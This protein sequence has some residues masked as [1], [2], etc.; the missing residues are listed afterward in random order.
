MQR[1]TRPR[2]SEAMVGYRDH[3]SLMWRMLRS[4]DL[5]ATIEANRRNAQRSTGPRTQ[6][7]QRQLRLNSVRHELTAETVPRRGRFQGIRS[8]N[9]RGH[10]VRKRPRRS[11]RAF[12]N[13]TQRAWESA[14]GPEFLGSSKTHV[15][16]D[17]A[18]SPSADEY[19]FQALKH[20]I[21]SS[22]RSKRTSASCIEEIRTSRR[23]APP[24]SA[25]RPKS[26]KIGIATKRHPSHSS[27]VSPRPWPAVIALLNYVALPECSGSGKS[28]SIL[29]GARLSFNQE[30]A[31]AAERFPPRE[32]LG[33]RRNCG[34]E[35]A[36]ADRAIRPV[37]CKQSHR[38]TLLGSE[39]V[40]ALWISFRSLPGLDMSIKSGLLR[41]F[42]RLLPFAVVNRGSQLAGGNRRP[43][44]QVEN[45]S[46]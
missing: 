8:D 46:I 41:C 27:R 6:D 30:A 10:I 36:M 29:D 12:L 7:G 21:Q 45:V 14:T 24:R 26:A 4:D 37:P 33:A 17:P 15:A 5:V 1:A 16:R 9:H 11:K 43:N 18:L 13:L 42:P 28:E 2:R 25:T 35:S 19:W 31:P 44:P 34:G 39:C 38:A 40:G 22:L 20:R 3:P 32:R 23:F